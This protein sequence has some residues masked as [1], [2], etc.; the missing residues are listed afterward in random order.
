MTNQ[1][2]CHF[3]TVSLQFWLLF[4]IYTHEQ[5]RILKFQDFVYQKVE[6]RA[7][8]INGWRKSK[9]SVVLL[10]RQSFHLIRPSSSSYSTEII[11]ILLGHKT[12]SCTYKSLW[13]FFNMEKNLLFINWDN[14]RIQRGNSYSYNTAMEC[15]IMTEMSL[16]RQSNLHRMT[17]LMSRS[18]LDVVVKKKKKKKIVMFFNFFLISGTILYIMKL[19]PFKKFCSASVTIQS[20][21]YQKFFL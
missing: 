7:Q 5:L 19:L 13:S 4:C 2:K 8:T 3:S 12:F 20:K 14:I 15:K 10:C 9:R 16:W 6:V 11:N 17:V 21:K 18:A 1:Q